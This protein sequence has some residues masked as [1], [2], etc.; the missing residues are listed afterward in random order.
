MRFV[1]T[2]SDQM[3]ENIN[4]VLIIL[5]T[6]TQH[7]CCWKHAGSLVEQT[8]LL[9]S[10]PPKSRRVTKCSESYGWTATSS[11]SSTRT[12]LPLSTT[13]KCFQ[14]TQFHFNKQFSILNSTKKL[15]S[16]ALKF[17]VYTF[18]TSSSRLQTH[19]IFNG[20]VPLHQRVPVLFFLDIKHLLR[21][22]C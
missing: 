6:L 21:H 3:K 12:M 14:S 8:C 7:T 9:P 22:I 4:N 15:L 20:L 19:P 5:S 2:K 10:A 16:I 17:F 13:L 18:P 1:S 11:L